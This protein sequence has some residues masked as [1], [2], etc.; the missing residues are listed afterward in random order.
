MKS[1]YPVLL[2]LAYKQWKQSISTIVSVKKSQWS[3]MTLDIWNHECSLPTLI[4]GYTNLQ[5]LV[6]RS[7]HHWMCWSG[8]LGCCEVL[9]PCYSLLHLE[10]PLASFSSIWLKLM[11]LFLG[12]GAFPPEQ[13][14]KERD[15]DLSL[16]ISKPL[17][18][19][20]NADQREIF[21]CTFNQCCMEWV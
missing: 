15:I 5:E 16:M 13:S 10:R 17:L 11:N 18:K 14:P 6:S 3:R 20:I 12:M 9:S 8:Q 1:I 2:I 21:H 19:I 4:S 7:Q